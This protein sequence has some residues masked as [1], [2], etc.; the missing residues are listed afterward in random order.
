MSLLYHTKSLVCLYMHS[1]TLLF[2]SELISHT[3][4]LYYILPTS[5]KQQYKTNIQ[6]RF[7][8]KEERNL[9]VLLELKCT[10]EFL[11]YWVFQTEGAHKKKSE[12]FCFS[13]KPFLLHVTSQGTQVHRDLKINDIKELPITVLVIENISG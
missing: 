10:W 8:Q 3:I 7:R 9:L 11:G 1:L 12:K 6:W 2:C 13:G 4:Y 5:G